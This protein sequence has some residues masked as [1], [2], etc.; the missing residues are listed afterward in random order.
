LKLNLDEE[1]RVTKRVSGGRMLLG[2]NRRQGSNVL[3]G[4]DRVKR[5]VNLL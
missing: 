4:K 3:V 1:L 2:F 5:K